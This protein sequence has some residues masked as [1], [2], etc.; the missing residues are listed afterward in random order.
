M[1]KLFSIL[2]VGLA[3]S[4]CQYSNSEPQKNST[5]ST[6]TEEASQKST[7]I[8]AKV[9]YLEFEGGFWG[10]ETQA[11]EKLLPMN[12]NKEFQQKDLNIWVEGEVMEGVITM[13]QWGKPFKVTHIKKR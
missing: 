9:I 4:A 8:A 3:L 5:T 13:H 2:C 10:I 6:V 12:L 1:K 11:G 7:E